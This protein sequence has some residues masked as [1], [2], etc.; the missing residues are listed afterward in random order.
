MTSSEHIS[1]RE[2]KGYYKKK[3]T[4]RIYIYKK[5]ELFSLFYL[6]GSCNRF[7][8]SYKKLIF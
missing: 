3:K 5:H 8:Q 1:E 4:C 7:L 2:F 6:W